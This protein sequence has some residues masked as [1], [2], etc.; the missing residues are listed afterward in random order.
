MTATVEKEQTAP[1][2]ED[3]VKAKYPRKAGEFR[4]IHNVFDDYFRVNFHSD[5]TNLVTRSYFVYVQKGKVVE[6]N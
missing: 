5:E 3:L 1:A 6:R 4:R 2:N